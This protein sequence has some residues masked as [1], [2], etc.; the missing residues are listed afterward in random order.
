MRAKSPPATPRCSACGAMPALPARCTWRSSNRTATIIAV[1]S[2]ECP[3]ETFP[4]VG[5]LHPPAIR[6]ERA[7]HSLY[8]LHPIGAPDARPWLDLGFWDVQSSARRTHVGT[9]CAPPLHVLAGGR[10][11]PASDPCWPGPCRH[12]RAGTFPLHRFGRNRG[13]AR[14]ALG[15]RAQGHRV[16]HGGCNDRTRRAACRPHLGRQHCRLRHRVRAR[17]RGGVGNGTA[18]ARAIFAC[19]DGGARTAGKSLRRHRR[20]LQ[21]C[22]VLAHE[23]A[24][25]HPA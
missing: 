2:L 21:R 14:T 13:T 8:G 11:K 24:L 4:S 19:A 20:H 16:A 10:R 22:L 12:H 25:R 18:A 9:G 6:L 17:R 3:D 15:L 1:V 7:I 5:A 23:R